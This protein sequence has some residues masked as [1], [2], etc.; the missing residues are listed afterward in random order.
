MYFGQTFGAFG[1][2]D[3]HVRDM[4]IDASASGVRVSVLAAPNLGDAY[5]QIYANNLF[6]GVV[7]CPEDT[8]SEPLTLA[9]PVSSEVQVTAFRIGPNSSIDQ[10]AF[11]RIYDTGASSVTAEWSWTYEI[12]GTQDS[13]FFSLWS[14]AGLTVSRVLPADRPTRGQIPVSLNV[15]GG[16]ATVTLGVLAQGS[17]PVGGSITLSPI[18]SS[19]VSGSVTV[20]AGATTESSTLSVRWPRSMSILRDTVSPPTVEV[21]SVPYNI[22]DTASFVDSVDAG[23]YYYAF[24]A[25]SDTDDIGDASA[26]ETVIVSGAPEPPTDIAYT[27]GGAAATVI[28]WTASPT[29]GATYN[30]Y[31]QN[32]GDPYLDTSTPTQTAIA[33]ATSATLPAITGF[34]GVARV[35]V[36]AEFAGV[37]EKNLD[38]LTLEYDSS[39][40]IVSQRPNT[41]QIESVSVST[42]L[43][44]GVGVLYDPTN[45]RVAPASVELYTRA[46]GASYNFLLPDSTAS[47]GTRANGDQVAN[48]SHTLASPGWYYATARTLTAGGQACNG[49]APE[50]AFYVSD[51]NASAPSGTF[52]ATR[53]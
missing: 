10:S 29:V 5:Y 50:V 13:T 2:P 36:R 8:Y 47:L 4:R 3:F 52:T 11:A 28:G 27:S 34:P 17:G 18:N 7:Y 26:P 31:V 30:I 33:G 43:T 41:P 42:G 32:I 9:L 40:V 20:D 37:E 53:G 38:T 39:G 46:L 23:T 24:R 49:Q 16:T 22:L 21:A 25:V 45:E 48:L 12:I 15:T 51:V 35:V 14:L 6:A 1:D 19:G 44:V